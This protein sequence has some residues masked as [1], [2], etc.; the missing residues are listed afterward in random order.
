MTTSEMETRELLAEMRKLREDV[1]RVGDD[2][3]DVMRR[4]GGDAFA[5]VQDFAEKVWH[6][7]KHRTDDLT[8]EIEKRP[9]TAALGAFGLGMLVGLIFSGRRA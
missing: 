5:K 8:R 9:L 4:L 7:A 6:E 3:Q 2:F 1:A